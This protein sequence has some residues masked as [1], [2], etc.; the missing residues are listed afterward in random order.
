MISVGGWPIDEVGEAMF[1]DE[2]ET[3]A[4]TTGGTGGGFVSLLLDT[5]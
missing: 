1:A 3:E 4:V 2:A 5:D